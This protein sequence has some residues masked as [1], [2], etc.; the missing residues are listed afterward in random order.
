MSSLINLLPIFL[1]L[2]LLY[3]TI[4]CFDLQEL[5][6]ACLPNDYIRSCANLGE[7]L[8]MMMMMI[9]NDTLILQIYVVRLYACWINKIGHV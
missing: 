8:M 9:V 4:N 1:S 3:R 6:E 5:L 7:S 2:S